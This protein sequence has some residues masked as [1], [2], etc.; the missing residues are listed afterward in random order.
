VPLEPK[1]RGG[2]PPTG[3][4]NRKHSGTLCTATRRDGSQCTNYAIRAATVCRMH[5]GSAPQVERAAQVRLLMAAE[6]VAGTLLEIAGD[7]SIPVAVRLAAVRDV[8]DRAGLAPAQQVALQAEVT[9]QPW[10]SKILGAVID[11]TD[12][13]AA[14]RQAQISRGI[15]PDADPNV[16]DAEVV[17]DNAR[18]VESDPERYRAAMND[19]SRA[20]T[21]LSARPSSRRRESR[22]S[23]LGE[24][25]LD[26]LRARTGR[27][28]E[29]TVH[30]G[31]LRVSGPGS[32]DRPLLAPAPEA[33]EMS[34]GHTRLVAPTRALAFGSPAH[35]GLFRPRKWRICRGV[36]RWS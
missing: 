21:E 6:R 16:V 22:A 32:P 11:T 26:C 24:P 20:C 3:L 13:E 19:A 27:S 12:L 4:E 1:G 5:G 2:P 25:G 15:D 30:E 18:D 31:R 29:A 23:E 34:Q 7:K 14:Y 8:L 17:E 36:S 9:V 28:T 33:A 35:P 10:E